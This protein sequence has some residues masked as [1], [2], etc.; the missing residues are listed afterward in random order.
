MDSWDLNT[1]LLPPRCGR[2]PDEPSWCWDHKQPFPRIPSR[3]RTPTSRK[4]PL[5]HLTASAELSLRRLPSMCQAKG[6]T[7]H[8]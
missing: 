7:S 2:R 1:F 3:A 4:V 8:L 6:Q 5:A